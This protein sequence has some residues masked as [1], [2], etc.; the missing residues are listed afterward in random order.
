[1]SG[2]PLTDPLPCWAFC[3][4]WGWPVPQSHSDEQGLL[5]EEGDKLQILGE[6][7]QWT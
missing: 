3:W 5:R 2:Q 4:A 7:L 1:M 6:W